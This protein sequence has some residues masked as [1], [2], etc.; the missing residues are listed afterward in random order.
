MSSPSPQPEFTP[1]DPE[2]IAAAAFLL[3]LSARP[4][5][6]AGAGI[7]SSKAEEELRQIAE[8]VGSPVITTAGGSDSFPDDH[9]LATGIHFDDPRA[10]DLLSHSDMILAI[11]TSFGTMPG[12]R[13]PALPA[14]MIHIDIDPAQINRVYPVRNAIVGDAKAALKLIIA[15][16]AA[17]APIQVLVDARAAEAPE[18]AAAARAA[19]SSAEPV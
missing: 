9:P 14:Q 15:E 17:S 19:A 12:S 6:L 13:T 10:H 8:L 18:R 5:I 1:L 11:G 2:Q 4:L 16:I 3:R 7:L